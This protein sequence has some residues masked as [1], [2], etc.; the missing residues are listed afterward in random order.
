MMIIEN[1]TSNTLKYVEDTDLRGVLYHALFLSLYVL[2][3]IYI[4]RVF[5]VLG[6]SLIILLIYKCINEHINGEKKKIYEHH[7]LNVN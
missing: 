6:A 1:L 4:E 2:V 5:Y 3:R 7:G